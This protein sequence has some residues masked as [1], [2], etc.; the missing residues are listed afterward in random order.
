MV[1]QSTRTV[2]HALRGQL[3]RCRSWVRDTTAKLDVHVVHT[4]A[5]AHSFQ[6]GAITEQ[7]SKSCRA[8]HGG[9]GNCTDLGQTD[10][11]LARRSRGGQ[12]C[13]CEGVLLYKTLKI[14]SLTATSL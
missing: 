13:S 7:D 1:C 10:H 6:R 11:F 4:S 14:A 5:L 8:G 3:C 12:V 2:A 9:L